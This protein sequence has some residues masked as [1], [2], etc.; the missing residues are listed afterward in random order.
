[1]QAKKEARLAKMAEIREK[2]RVF[3]L[4]VACSKKPS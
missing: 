1:L 4:Q 2:V 3:G